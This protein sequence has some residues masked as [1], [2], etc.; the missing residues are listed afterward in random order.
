MALVRSRA[1]AVTWTAF[2]ALAAP[3]LL[4]AQEP[5]Q[6][7][8]QP[9]AQ[10]VPVA[11]PSE[12]APPA[13]PA[14]PPATEPGPSG[15]QPAAAPA[16][17]EAAPEEVVA[18]PAE[19]D[20]GAEPEPDAAERG[21]DAS[22]RAR[23]AA[24]AS[25]TIK[26]FSFAP[27]ALTVNVGDTVT[28]SNVGPT[29]HTATGDGFDTGNLAKGASGSHTFTAAGTFSYICT[30]HPFMKASVTVAAASGGE[31]DA[32]SGAEADAGSDTAT[33]AGGADG[34]ALPDTGADAWAL[35]L[36]GTG[37]LA[38]GFAARRRTGRLR[39]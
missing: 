20:P 6:P 16:P 7:A 28:W 24:S 10:T 36:L 1:F 4:M 39:G 32:G 35:A 23:K 31:D 21:R 12:A 19:A 29:V 14:A 37:L 27:S 30:P 13:E 25:V 15:E 2:T 9:P 5:P 17:E 11:P 3:A 33:A 22:P 26:D 38:F 34:P 8:N 18:E